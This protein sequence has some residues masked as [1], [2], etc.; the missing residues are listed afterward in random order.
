MYFNHLTQKSTKQHKNDLV[1]KTLS[2]MEKNKSLTCAEINKYSIIEY[3]RNKGI[4]PAEKLRNRFRYYSPIRNE[5]TPSF[6]VSLEK[7]VWIDRGTGEGGTLVDLC[8][9]LENLS[10]SEVVKKFN[11]DSFSFHQLNIAKPKIEKTSSFKILS[12]ELLKEKRLCD[13]LEERAIKLPVAKRMVNEYHY[14]LNSRNYFGI[15]IDNVKGGVELRNKYFKGTL[16]PKAISYFK[17]N[18]NKIL[19][20]E[21][22]MDLLSHFSY[23]KKEHT[24]NHII[25][26]NSTNNT[27]AAKEQVLQ[28]PKNMEVFLFLDR[29]EAGKRSGQIF[30]NLDRKIFDMSYIYK[31]YNDYNEMLINKPNPK[32]SKGMSM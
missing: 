7:N 28:L 30:Q 11:N 26:L 16:G 27:L 6:D 23:S 18:N 31:G 10:V 20:F 5:S 9:K 2:K 1:I 24:S 19:V 14:S 12:K 25:I 29:D 4:D 3:L 32:K 13:Y 15:G 17:G 8:T 22:F 21:G